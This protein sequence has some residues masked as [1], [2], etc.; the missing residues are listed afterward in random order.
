MNELELKEMSYDIKTPED[1]SRITLIL[2]RIKEMKD[3]ICKKIDPEISNAY[4]THK[5]LTA[6]K[7]DTLLPFNNGK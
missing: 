3:A 1:L 2:R 5:G 4:K 6:L 7:K